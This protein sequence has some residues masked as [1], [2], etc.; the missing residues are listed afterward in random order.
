[1]VQVTRLFLGGPNYLLAAP[2]RR[3][4]RRKK[5]RTKKIDVR[6]GNRAPVVTATTS[7]STTKPR[8][9]QILLGPPLAGNFAGLQYCWGRQAMLQGIA[10]AIL[11]AVKQWRGGP[12]RRN[13]VWVVSNIARVCAG[14]IAG[15][16]TIP[17]AGLWSLAQYCRSDPAMLQGN[18]P[19]ILHATKQWVAGPAR[20][21]IVWVV[22]NIAGV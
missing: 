8:S 16:Q 15:T 14:N 9:V 6:A 20:R 1:V 2:R 17:Q 21:N 19:A 5:E 12:T 4:R 13:I 3:R 11:Y 7:S 22:S 10:P 18:V